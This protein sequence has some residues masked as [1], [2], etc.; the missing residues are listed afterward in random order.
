MIASYS[1][2]EVFTPDE[3]EL[4]RRAVRYVD[5]IPEY[6]ADSRCHEVARAVGE[7]LSLPHQDGF[8]GFVDHTW[9]WTRPLDRTAGRMGRIGFPH[10]LDVYRV[11]SL[12]MVALVDGAHTSLPHVGWAYRPGTERTDVDSDRVKTLVH[13]MDEAMHASPA[14]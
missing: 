6:L 12:P 11:G 4:W 14:H 8:Y 1:E 5:R 3:V 7:L 10:V 13:A 9:L 2:R